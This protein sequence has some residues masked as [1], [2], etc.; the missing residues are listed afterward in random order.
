MHQITELINADW[1]IHRETL[2]NS[3]PIF[4]HVMNG[5]KLDLTALLDSSKSYVVQH[6]NINVV[7]S[8]SLDDSNI[9]DNSVAVIPLEGVIYPGKSQ[10]LVRDIQIAEMNPQISAIMLLIN[11]PGGT[12]FY[13]DIAALKIQT[14]EKPVVAYVRNMAASGAMWLVSASKHIIASSSLDQFGSIGVK[15]SYQDLNDF[16]KEKLGI[17]VY[18]IYASKSTLKDG[19]IRAL[20]EGDDKPI[21]KRL[22]FINDIFHKTIRENLGIAEA[23]DVFSGDMYFA[24]DAISKGLC[25]DIM[26]LEEAINYT[27]KQGLAHQIK[28]QIY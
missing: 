8:Y 16:L 20:L 5:G 9:P 12:V 22:D 28:S 19:A 17:T 25:H 23:S 6:D 10:R 27:Y 3:L 14:S 11:S 24:A 7:N 15:T 18:D 4:L 2:L 1:L 26:N 13:T 21:V